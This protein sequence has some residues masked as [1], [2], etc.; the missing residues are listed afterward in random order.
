MCSEISFDSGEVALTRLVE[1]KPD[2]ER[3]AGELGKLRRV[4]DEPARQRSQLV[5]ALLGG[6]GV[7]PFRESAATVPLR[8]MGRRFS[9]ARRRRR[10]FLLGE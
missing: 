10:R 2:R 6:Y 1:K 4:S 7:E 8:R 5:G 9:G 3:A